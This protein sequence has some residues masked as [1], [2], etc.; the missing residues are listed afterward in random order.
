MEKL[1]KKGTTR[2]RRNLVASSGKTEENHNELNSVLRQFALATVEKGVNGLVTEFADIK[3]ATSVP[4]V[5]T[6]FEGKNKF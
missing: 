1:P 6:A 4:P 3:Q 5:K 2:R